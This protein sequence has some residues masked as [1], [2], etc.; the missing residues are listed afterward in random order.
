MTTRHI[1][2]GV[3]ILAGAACIGVL[4]NCRAEPTWR[5]LDSDTLLAVYGGQLC[6]DDPEPNCP[7]VPGGGSCGSEGN[8]YLINGSYRCLTDWVEEK[9]STTGIG[10]C[11]DV[12]E[13]QIQCHQESMPCRIRHVCEKNADCAEV[14]DRFEC[15]QDYATFTGYEDTTDAGSGACEP[16][17]SGNG[18]VSPSQRLAA[19]LAMN[20]LHYSP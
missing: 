8:C 17:T 14:F 4:L 16:Q 6:Y 18:R 5:N 9:N 20:G 3:S 10:L 12:V 15:R 11:P 1:L 13:G 7:D 2:S 19:T